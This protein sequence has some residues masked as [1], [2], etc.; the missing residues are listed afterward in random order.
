MK[1]SNAEKLKAE[2]FKSRDPR[3]VDQTWQGLS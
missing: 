2:F 1:N 3:A